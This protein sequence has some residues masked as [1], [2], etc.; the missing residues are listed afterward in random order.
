VAKQFRSLENQDAA[1]RKDDILRAA[2]SAFAA[3]SRPS[4]RDLNQI[5]DLALPII[6]LTSDATRR[7]VAA[8]L[9]DAKQAPQAL[10]RRICEEAPEICAPLLLR[11]P[12]LTALDLVAII[13][14]KGI[15]H[16][17]IISKREHLPNSVI[18][19]LALLNDPV[20]RQRASSGGSVHDMAGAA[21]DTNLKPVS[22]DAARE[23]LRGFMVDATLSEAQAMANLHEQTPLAAHSITDRLVELALHREEGLFVTLLAD[24]SGL[25]F[26]Q[27]L[28]LIR[29]KSP[30]ELCTIL[31]VFGVAAYPAFVM[32]SAFFPQIAST[33]TEISLFLK[34][35]QTLDSAQSQDMVRS[36]KA[37]E[38]SMSVP[39]YAANTE[40]DIEL[41]LLTEDDLLMVS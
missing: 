39:R 31:N 32:C 37:E 17:H 8:A 24:Q 6:P 36:W 4:K 2:V 27:C 13:G 29:R 22:A 33:K 1:T 30:S 3:L 18:E 35:F 28:K 38:I 34:R 11:S 41:D 21:I 14:R 26:K 23:L 15:G 40:A 19:A 9:C 20:A 16:A 10:V 5:E 12:V 7:F 25:T